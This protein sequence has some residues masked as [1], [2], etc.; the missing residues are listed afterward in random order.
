M[1]LVGEQQRFG[2]AATEYVDVEVATSGGDSILLLAPSHMQRTFRH[3]INATPTRSALAPVLE[4]TRTPVRP[5]GL[6]T[7]SQM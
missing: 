5:L 1:I 2:V 7:L 4:L 6:Q 3:V